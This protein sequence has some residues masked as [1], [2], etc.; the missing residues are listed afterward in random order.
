MGAATLINISIVV[1]AT[2]LTAA[3]IYLSRNMFGITRGKRI[4]VYATP[5]RA[6]LV[7]DIQESSGNS[8]ARSE[9]PPI[10]TPFGMMLHNV[11]RLIDGFALAGNKVA[12]IR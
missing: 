10:A 2:L 7:M 8:V 1:V 4:A 5:A 6:L 9:Q 11:N 3:I 12:Y